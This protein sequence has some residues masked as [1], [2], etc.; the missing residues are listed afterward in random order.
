MAAIPARLDQRQVAAIALGLAEADPPEVVSTTRAGAR[1]A[2]ARARGALSRRLLDEI[3]APSASVDVG[4]WGPAVCEVEAD[5]HLREA[6]DRGLIYLDPAA[7]ADAP[8]PLRH[9]Q[10][11]LR[12][13]TA[14][15]A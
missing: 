15:N 2:L 10:R 9:V 6:L 1:S 3:W 11:L 7:P 4:V 12:R 13:L 14:P 8:S 5:R